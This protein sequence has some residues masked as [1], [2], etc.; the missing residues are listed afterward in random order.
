MG[1]G[2]VRRA[3]M[4]FL[5]FM[6]LVPEWAR[7]RAGPQLRELASCGQMESGSRIHAT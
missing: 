2:S 3:K 4:H 6:G 1:L 5:K 7:E